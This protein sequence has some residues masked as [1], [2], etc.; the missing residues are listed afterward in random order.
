ML[1]QQ[2]KQEKALILAEDGQHW[3]VLPV[4]RWRHG[5]T[6]LELGLIVA[7]RWHEVRRLNL[8]QVLWAQDP[9]AVLAAAPVLTYADLD[10]VLADGWQGD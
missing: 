3:P 4:K 8:W 5:N 7:P 2:Q 9:Q 10:A 6:D 1:T